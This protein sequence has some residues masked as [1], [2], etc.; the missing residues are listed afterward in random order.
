MLS[1]FSG[2]CHTYRVHSKGLSALFTVFT[3]FSED[4]IWYIYHE[5]KIMGADTHNV[6]INISISMPIIGSNTIALLAPPIGFLYK[7]IWLNEYAYRD[8]LVDS[9]G[10]PQID[11]LYAIH[12]ESEKYIICLELESIKSITH[13]GAANSIGFMNGDDFDLLIEPIHQ[14]YEAQL[15]EYFS[16]LHLYKEGEVARKHTFYTYKTQEGIC[17]SNR[18]ITPVI[19]DIVTIIRYPMIISENEIPS[20][21]CFLFSHRKSY[22]MLRPIVIDELEYTYHTLDDATN[23]K[24]MITPLEVLFLR[25]DYGDKKEMLSKRMAAFLGDNDAEMKSI[26]DNLKNHYT[27]RSDAIHEGSIQQ[28][29][30]NSLHELRNLVR[31]ATKKYMSLIEVALGAN[32]L[33]T[34]D[35]IKRDL[36]NTLKATVRT[37]NAL[38]IW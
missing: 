33:I 31:K 16:M 27:D 29:T 5:V 28:I 3:L 20:L 15:F 26:Y 14:N 10:N 18:S 32:P 6:D 25:N 37:K 34:F 30:Q 11:Y 19:V 36:I 17:S 21:N 9:S 4:V 8:K 35:E 23:Y 13:S 22:K 2:G 12:G 38:N 7:K 1:E 24:N